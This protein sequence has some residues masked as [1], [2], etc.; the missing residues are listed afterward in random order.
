MHS[1]L[2][3]PIHYLMTHCLLVLG[4]IGQAI[5]S[6]RFLIQWI[7]SER[8]QR[9]VVPVIFWYFSV[10]GGTLLLLYAVFRKDPVFILGQAGGLMIYVRNLFLI[11]KERSMHGYTMNVPSTGSNL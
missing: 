1:A 9:S 3:D 8:Q 6:G 7:A 11:Y 2:N 4:L 10:A 5:F